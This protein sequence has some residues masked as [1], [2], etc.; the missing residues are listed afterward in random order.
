MTL[1]CKNCIFFIF[2]FYSF[3]GA[4]IIPFLVMMVLEGMPLLL[5]ELGIGQRMRTG[6]FGVWNRV[7]PLLGGI[8]LGS[9]VVA[10]IV[11]CYYNVIIAWCLFYLYNSLSVGKMKIIYTY[12][13]LKKFER[14]CFKNAY[15]L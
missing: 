4:F 5:L 7:N 1:L 10:M 13:C 14:N 2:F 12:S 11:G 6:S 3:S 15:V 9:T 8:G